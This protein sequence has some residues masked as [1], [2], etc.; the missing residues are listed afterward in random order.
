MLRS[1]TTGVIEPTVLVDIAYLSV[2]S[3]I[4]VAITSRRLRI[5]LL[6]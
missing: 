4:G 6:K 5:L 1:F 3:L 2:M